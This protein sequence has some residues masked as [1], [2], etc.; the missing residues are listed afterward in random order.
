MR[1]FVHDDGGPRIVFGPG[2][3]AQLADEVSRLGGSRALVLSTPGR[4]DLAG[5]VVEVLG[6]SV[7]GTFDGA[8]M[9]TPVEVTERALEGGAVSTPTRWSRSVAGRRPG[10]ARPWP[11]GP[12]SR[13]W[14][15]DDVRRLRGHPGAG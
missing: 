1:T 15:A 7:A 3:L 6:D 8:T 13:T 11:S 2:A 9:H 4:R 14:S 12:G 10:S 5:R